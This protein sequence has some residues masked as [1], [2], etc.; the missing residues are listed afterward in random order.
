M[1]M[2]QEWL[3]SN[4]DWIRFSANEEC[5]PFSPMA[6]TPNTKEILSLFVSFLICEGFLYDGR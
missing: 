6:S 3:L 4:A 2:C 5:D 1:Y